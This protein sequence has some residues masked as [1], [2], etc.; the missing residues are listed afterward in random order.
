MKYLVIIMMLFTYSCSDYTD[1][2]VYE[3]SIK[4][5]L[6]QRKT[7]TIE[8]PTGLFSPYF[9]KY[10]SVEV[11]IYDSDYRFGFAHVRVW[12]GTP[13]ANWVSEKLDLVTFFNDVGDPNTA[14]PFY[15][16]I[17]LERFLKSRV[18]KSFG[19]VRISHLDKLTDYESVRYKPQ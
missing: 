16:L 18:Y 4:E 7:H 2:S 17:S 6:S 5:R 3:Q 13:D 11:I 8:G 9:V 1:Y 10:D 19:S 12:Y 15:P 14:Y